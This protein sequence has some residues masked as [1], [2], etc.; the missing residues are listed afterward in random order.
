[1]MTTTESAHGH[2][3]CSEPPFKALLGVQIDLLSLGYFFQNILDHNAIVHADITATQHRPRYICDS[4]W[5]QLDVVVRLNDVDI[6][7]SI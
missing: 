1:M 5:S 6:Q 3:D 7:L 4:R 2:P